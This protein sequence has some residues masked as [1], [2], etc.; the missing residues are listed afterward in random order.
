MAFESNNQRRLAEKA[1]N[2]GHS[3]TYD[4]MN[5]YPILP[6]TSYPLPLHALKVTYAK[7]GRLS[8][9]M[10]CAVDI[11]FTPKVITLP[12]S[13]QTDFVAD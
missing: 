9:G 5:A 13:T 2:K 3:S 10:T 6:I 1:P 12:S 11:A 8:A 7:P 4:G